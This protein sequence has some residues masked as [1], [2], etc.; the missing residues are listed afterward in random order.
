M[1]EERRASRL[2]D[3]PPVTARQ[4]INS[5]IGRFLE[6]AARPERELQRLLTRPSLRFDIR[7]HWDAFDAYPWFAYGMLEAARQAHALGKP[8]LTA[9]EFGVAGGNGLVTMERY[10]AEIA[11]L[12]GVRWEIIGM[13]MGPGGM[14]PAASNRDLPYAWQ[15]GQFEMDVPKLKARLHRAQV[16]LGDV[17]ETIDELLARELPPVGF[18]S[19]DMDYYTSTVPALRLFDAP[20]ERLLPRPF[21]YLDDVV[22]DADELHSKF[23]GELLAVEEFNAAHDN[24]KIAPIYGLEYKRIIPAVWNLQMHVAHLFDHPEYSTYIG[25]E[26]RQLPLRES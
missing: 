19:Y 10:A 24:R 9:V 16:I 15:A 17:H 13:D 8:A 4:A 1:R 2:V 25:P 22:G 18:V 26:R 3:S 11:H 6:R 20:A 23:A 21:V 14:P 12:T 7:T 5:R